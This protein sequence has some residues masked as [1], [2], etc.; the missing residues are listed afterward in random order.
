M[1]EVRAA[2]ARVS[3][4]AA[5]LVAPSFAAHVRDLPLE[6]RARSVFCVLL[7]GF[8]TKTETAHSLYVKQ[9]HNVFCTFAFIKLKIGTNL[10]NFVTWQFHSIM[11]SRTS[12]RSRGL[13]ACTSAASWQKCKRS[14]SLPVSVR[15]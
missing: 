14:N 10:L 13:A 12:L 8:S 1:F 2:R 6:Y 5:L 9:N 3:W 7:R 11:A 15:I 4:A